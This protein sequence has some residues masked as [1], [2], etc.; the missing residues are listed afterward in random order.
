[1]PTSTHNATRMGT[2]FIIKKLDPKNS[3]CYLSNFALTSRE[4]TINGITYTQIFFFGGCS[5]IGIDFNDMYLL[6][7]ISGSSQKH[8]IMM[9][10]TWHRIP[11]ED[12]N[13][14]FIP[15]PRNSH[16]LDLIGDRLYLFGGCS[17]WSR[18]TDIENLLYYFDLNDLHWKLA[19]VS[20]RNVPS[21]RF[22]HSSFVYEGCLYILFGF[23]YKALGDMW[24][25]DNKSN[26]WEQLC[27][28]CDKNA[29]P[30]PRYGQKVILVNDCV[31]MFGG[32][33]QN[34]CSLPELWK[35]NLKTWSWSKI[36]CD[37]TFI[38]FKEHSLLSYGNKI[39]FCGGRTRT[40]PAISDIVIFDTRKEC[41]Y[42]L[43]L[44]SLDFRLFDHQMVGL[45]NKILVLGGYYGFFKYNKVT[46]VEI[47]DDHFPSFDEYFADDEDDQCN[48]YNSNGNCCNNNDNDYNHRISPNTCST[49]SH[50][51]NDDMEALIT[52]VSDEF[53]QST[54]STGANEIENV[55][56]LLP[57][58]TVNTLNINTIFVDGEI[59]VDQENV[60]L[61]C[62]NI[63]KVENYGGCE[64]KI[65]TTP[66]P[67]PPPIMS[68]RI[69]HQTWPNGNGKWK[70]RKFF[71]SPISREDL[72]ESIFKLNGILE[73][74]EK[75]QLNEIDLIE[76][77][78]VASTA[79]VSNEG[80]SESTDITSSATVSMSS[81]IFINSSN[82]NIVS[83]LPANRANNIGIKLRN[84]M[85]DDSM[86]SIQDICDMIIK[87]QLTEEQIDSLLSIIP[88]DE[89]E[90]NLLDEFH[91]IPSALADP[92]RF[93]YEVRR[94][95]YL[96]ERLKCMK[97]RSSFISRSKKLL[98]D[99]DAVIYACMEISG[100]EFCQFLE[101]V[102]AIIRF[103]NASS[104]DGFSGFKMESLLKLRDTKSTDN[105][106]TLL[107]YIVEFIS[108]KYP[109]LLDLKTI[110]KHVDALGSV[111]QIQDI[112]EEFA[113]LK[114]S[115]NL[116][117]IQMD[118]ILTA[119]EN[120]KDP[121]DQKT[122]MIRARDLFAEHM[123]KDNFLEATQSIMKEIIDKIK[124]MK[125]DLQKLSKLM[126]EKESVVV[127][128]SEFFIGMRN[129][130]TIFDGTVKIFQ[131]KEKE[132]L[133]LI[134]SKV[135][136]KSNRLK[137]WRGM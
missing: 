72:N 9:P 48:S 131:R 92:D 111:I 52:V 51:G 124:K 55:N 128:T 108:K 107:E 56:L 12:Q 32:Q 93:H 135:E 84:L 45:K 76:K 87:C 88:A 59:V 40:G 123:R 2:D 99:M 66:P 94:I 34:G 57:H 10:S 100:K 136:N 75:I 65:V 39:L 63:P 102:V 18:F 54:Y 104:L 67:P 91:G 43:G 95:P 62:Q 53:R 89:Q 110:L 86:S 105:K 114:G 21:E 33:E 19:E 5:T 49:Q 129:F 78:G 85:K 82:N 11:I 58:T 118:I 115:W 36:S 46:V 64:R 61:I 20:G 41:F 16:T 109:V 121:S 96:Q 120:E 3:P 122:F 50:K 127:Y 134:S 74:A 126:N 69:S 25:F 106:T 83:L 73:G 98:E 26:R 133:L 1:M 23:N 28:L 7:F 71:V 35:W 4:I 130:I 112:H 81:K 90:L 116:L 119:T 27:C 117:K 13:A 101:I 97:F 44:N 47:S 15:K 137:L 79:S 22:S 103:L 17:Y 113:K 125:D 24:K 6:S 14:I 38:P 8:N 77:F 60:S 132:E 29:L 37:P 30:N 68:S 80:D 70:L 31:F 42:V